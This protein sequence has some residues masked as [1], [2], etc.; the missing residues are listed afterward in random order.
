MIRTLAKRLIPSSVL[1]TVRINTQSFVA[2]PPI[3]VYQ[4]GKVGSRTVFRSL[5]NA[6]QNR[7]IYHVHFLSHEGIRRAEE[8]GLGLR[9]PVVPAH[10]GRSKILSKK[11]DR[12]KS[13]VCWQIVTLVR[14]PIGWE[15]SNFFHNATSHYPDLVD[16]D[17]RVKTVAA[18]KLL[19]ARLADYN[20]HE[21]YPCT[22]F[23][24]E[25]R[26][27][28]DTDVYAHPFDHQAGFTIIR[29]RNVE[30]LILRV[31]DLDHTLSRAATEFLGLNGPIRITKANMARTKKYVDEYRYVLKNIAVPESACLR[32]YSSRYASHF[33]TAAMRDEF[34][35]RWTGASVRNGLS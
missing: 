27:V 32:I 4:M 5:R 1:D 34:T 6:A 20:E 3:L 29:E 7:P 17:G 30:I 10:I 2:N 14:D 19:C 21:S 26:R 13:K 8:Y 22:W 9:D 11:I 18:T 25:L 35:R 24:Q 15:I 28:F 23:D 16:R 12:V 33:Y 31:E